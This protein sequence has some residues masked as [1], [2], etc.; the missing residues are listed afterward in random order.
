[1][2]EFYILEPLVIQ[3]MSHS[4]NLGISFLTRNNLKLVCTEDKVS[5]MPVS[6]WSASRARL[7][8]EVCNSFIN[9]RS[10]KVLRATKE[11]IST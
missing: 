5:L 4:V 1:M 3:G 2:E 7:V 6:D 11:Q 8:D 9:Q 10:G